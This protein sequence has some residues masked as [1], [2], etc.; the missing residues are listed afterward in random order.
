MKGKE[1]LNLERAGG[2]GHMKA[3]NGRGMW[4]TYI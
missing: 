1:P 3:G 4:C 2:G